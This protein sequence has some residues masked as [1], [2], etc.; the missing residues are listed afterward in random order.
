MACRESSHGSY[1]MHICENQHEVHTAKE[2][3]I[4]YFRSILPAFLSDPATP[5]PHIAYFLG[6]V[7]RLQA[8]R[9]EDLTSKSMNL[10]HY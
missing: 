8:M 4:R 7:K 1:S 3:L 2:T 6:L 10:S 5:P 9:P